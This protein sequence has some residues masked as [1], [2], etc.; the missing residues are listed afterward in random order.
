MTN[1]ANVL[2]DSNASYEAFL[3]ETR[4]TR[5]LFGDGTLSGTDIE[6]HVREVPESFNQE[7]DLIICIG[8]NPTN[9][10]LSNTCLIVNSHGE[11]D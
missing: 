11:N 5:Q 4:K 3:D 7:N 6:T 2:M 8:D 9:D 1:Q 10:R